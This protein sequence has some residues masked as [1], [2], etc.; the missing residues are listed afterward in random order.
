MPHATDPD[1]P[2]P[3]WA[4]RCYS[5]LVSL[6]LAVPLLWPAIPPLTDIFGHLARY[7]IVERIGTSPYLHQWFAT[8]WQLSGNLGVD[9]IA[10]AFD[11]AFDIV[12]V[13]K[14]TMIATAVL[15]GGG[16]LF[17]ARE[18]HG[19]LPPTA[20][21]ALPLVFGM[22][23]HYGFLNY[24]LSVALV[25]PAIA[26]WLRLGLRRGLRR[27]RGIVRAALFVPLSLAIWITH[28]AG[29]GLLGLTVFAI[30]LATARRDGTPYWRAVIACLPLAAPLAL[31]LFQPTGPATIGISHWFDGSLKVLFVLAVLRDQ[32][33]VF[34]I[35]SAALLYILVVFGLRGMGFR[36]EPR[37]ACAAAAVF[38][39]FLL[40]PGMIMGSALAD[41]RV[42]PCALALA[43][44]SLSPTNT[45][46]RNL[47][48]LA[49]AALAFLGLRLA[50][51]TIGWAR[52]ATLQ[53]EQ[54][55][56]LDHIPRGSRVF[57]LVTLPC[58][59][60]WSSRRMDH[61]GLM[62]IVRRD[63]F[64]NGMWNMPSSQLTVHR[65]DATGFVYAGSQTLFPAGCRYD[66]RYDLPR[67]LATMPRAA[68]DFVWLIDTPRADW[69]NDRGLHRIWSGNRGALYRIAH[70]P[71]R[72][73]PPAPAAT[74]P[75]L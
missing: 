47:D 30:E 37:L 69:P 32:N 10:A 25:F 64:A 48:L 39:A 11:P 4:T 44:L 21:F 8:H 66:P 46:Q 50:V 23:F 20:P 61:L 51:Q 15:T 9:L 57:V 63:A 29:W 16:M 34:D 58:E 33:A 36:M 18:A 19:R 67:A 38:A 56:A 13:T 60:A 72:A 59:S 26:L 24:S 55:A 68:F 53:Q 75:R 45:A 41:M 14:I 49:I 42:L 5:V 40:L 6:L 54:L 2:K 3:W 74:I 22:P 62:A 1:R 27:D 43:I 71:I 35:A 17:V 52:T 70:R 7:T 12:L 28:L 31:L 65:P 73:L